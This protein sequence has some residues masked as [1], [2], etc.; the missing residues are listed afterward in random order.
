MVGVRRFDKQGQLESLVARARDRA[1][2]LAMSKPKDLSQLPT[3]K[4]R[5]LD[6]VVEV[7]RE[8]FA[9]K[10]ANRTSARLRDAKILKIILYGSYARGDWVEDPIG[11]YWSD[12][13]ILVVTESE[14]TADFTEFWAEAEDRLMQ[15]LAEGKEL[16]TPVSLI[17]HSI[18]DV[19]DQLQKGR[20]FFVDIAREGIVL[21]S[22]PGHPFIEPK[23]L[24]A[25]AA[26]QEATTYFE[27]STTTAMGLLD[28]SRYTASQGRLKET[29]FSLHQAAETLYQCL[30][31]VMTLHTPNTHNLMRLRKLTDSFDPRLLGVWPTETKF[32]RRSFEL[33]KQGYV[34]ARYSEHYQVTADELAFMRERIEVLGA[35]VVELSQAQIAAFEAA[36]KSS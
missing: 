3:V 1:I 20:Y 16:R 15:A 4:R 23:G 25:E 29:A 22:V 33:L 9:K 2:T 11:R 5:E 19:N 27:R 31:L 17:T 14:D 36:S 7:L 34:N 21:L 26:L 12:Y 35:L 30:I 8:E 13:D 28:T 18:D 10:T 32:Q 6:Y 24:P